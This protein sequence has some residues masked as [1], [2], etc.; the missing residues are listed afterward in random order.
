MAGA[1]V[2]FASSCKKEKTTT[3]LLQNGAW[4]IT[5]LTATS[6]ASSIDVYA[7]MPSCS[8][9]D[10]YTFKTDNTMIQGAGATKCA[11]TDPDT[12]S[13]G[14]YA[15]NGSTVTLT[16]NGTV[17]TFNIVSISETGLNATRVDNNV[18]YN[19]TYAH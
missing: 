16:N 6:G 12:Q 7:T 14:T 3:E 4:K 17:T 15:V 9:D 11:T 2:L 10:L 13:L 8:K 5:A 18:T 19:M 1:L